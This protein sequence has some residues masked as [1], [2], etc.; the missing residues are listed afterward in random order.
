MTSFITFFLEVICL[1]LNVL[2]EASTFVATFLQGKDRL[3]GLLPVVEDWHAKVC[4][5]GVCAILYSITVI[6]YCKI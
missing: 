4:L 3:E 5:L 6:D 1:L 2:E